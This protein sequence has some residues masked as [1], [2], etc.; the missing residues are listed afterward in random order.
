MHAAMRHVPHDDERI[1]KH[2]MAAAFIARH[3][4]V[5]EAALA[6]LGKELQDLFTSGDAQWA[7][8]RADQRGLRCARSAN[9]DAAI[10]EC[11]ADFG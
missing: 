7:D 9:G 5:T 1:D 11:C 10:V 8:V 2:C 3:C 4:S 6:S